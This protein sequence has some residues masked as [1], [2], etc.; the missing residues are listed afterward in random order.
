MAGGNSKGREQVLPPFVNNSL[1]SAA[2]TCLVDAK[3]A[4]TEVTAIEFL[5]G[6]TCLIVVTHFDKTEAA[7]TT[8]LPVRDD[9]CRL[10]RAVLGEGFLEI[11]SGR[12]E[13]KI[14]YV[15]VHN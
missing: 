1:G 11:C 10:D 7:G 3:I 6:T 8:G 15:D 9:C 14:P 13:G 5:D 2:R 4:T 12:G